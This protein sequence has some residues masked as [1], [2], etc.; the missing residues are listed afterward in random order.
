MAV[1]IQ[2]IKVEVAKKNLFPALIAKQ[3]DYNSRFLKA[4]LCDNGE[5]I[6]INPT[7]TVTINANRPDGTC[8][9]FP[10]VSNDDD[11]VTVPLDA[12]MLKLPGIVY[13]DISVTKPGENMLTSTSFSIDV[14][15]AAAF[16]EDKDE[17]K[18]LNVT[19]T[20]FSSSSYT[21]ISLYINGE[22]QY[23]TPENGSSN[24]DIVY[25]NTFENVSEAYIVFEGNMSGDALTEV[26]GTRVWTDAPVVG[27]QY[28]L[29][30][31]DTNTISIRTDFCH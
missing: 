28:D 17:G 19:T 16:E 26:N 1:I 22:K 29:L 2:E 20:C 14:E 24:A 5:P 13:C 11:T 9:R 30:S 8:K 10:G 3:Y 27:A 21:S 23:T 15:P 12:W 6:T 25:S 18:T 31:L 7:S 4:T